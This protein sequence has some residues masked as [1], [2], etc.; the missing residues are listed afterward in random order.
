MLQ[1]FT[2]LV[3]LTV[4]CGFQCL[5]LQQF[6]CKT[7]LTTCKLPSHRHIYVSVV[8]ISPYELI[9]YTQFLLSHGVERV[10][11]TRLCLVTWIL[12]LFTR[13]TFSHLNHGPNE[14]KTQHN[15]QLHFHH[16]CL[17]SEQYT[18]KGWRVWMEQVCQVCILTPED[19]MKK[20]LYT[21]VVIVQY[22]I[23]PGL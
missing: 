18:W 12:R 4:H 2:F 16:H 9:L 23:T 7:I 21:N 11:C 22:P 15:K 13:C 1:M 8:S 5:L 14:D 17:V 20:L 3:W 6:I 19:A 10:K